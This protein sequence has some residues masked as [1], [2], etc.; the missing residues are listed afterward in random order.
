MAFY[1]HLRDTNM[2]SR[3]EETE[4]TGYLSVHAKLLALIN[5][6][7]YIYIYRERESETKREGKKETEKKL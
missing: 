2:K 5:C 4:R 6:A 3:K 1:V 7:I